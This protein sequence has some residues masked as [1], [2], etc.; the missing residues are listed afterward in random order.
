MVKLADAFEDHTSR[1]ELAAL[2]A[3]AEQHGVNMPSSYADLFHRKF[4]A[5]PIR[6]AHAKMFAGGVRGGWIQVTTPSVYRAE[7]CFQYDLR[8]AYLWSIAQGLP[9]PGSFFIVNGYC[10]PGVYWVNSPAQQGYPYPW[11]REGIFPASSEE[12]EFYCLKSRVTGKGI[13]FEQGTA[14]TAGMVRDIRSWSAWKNIARSMWGRWAASEGPTMETLTPEGDIRTARAMP[15]L[16]ACPTWAVIIT[17]RVRLR[18]AEQFDK[19]GVLL[20]L[21]DAV[22]T[23]REIPTGE[24]V[25]DWRLVAEYPQGGIISLAGITGNAA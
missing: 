23:N 15:P 18:M 20:V 13:L 19:G 11:H 10:G 9:D 12:I 5:P 8:S 24:D 25:G 17:S 16:W 21:T 4:F 3:E 1:N 6:R 7:H 14:D 22:V 2:L